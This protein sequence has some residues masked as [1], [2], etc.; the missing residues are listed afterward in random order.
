MN[1]ESGNFNEVSYGKHKLYF[2]KT[3][4]VKQRFNHKNKTRRFPYHENIL[5]FLEENSDH[6]IYFTLWMVFLVG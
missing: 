2:E 1:V 4:T 5:K 3:F 6:K